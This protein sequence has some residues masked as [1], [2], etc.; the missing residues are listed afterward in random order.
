MPG[1]DEDVEFVDGQ[2]EPANGGD[3]IDCGSA[4]PEWTAVTVVVAVLVLAGA[5]LVLTSRHRDRPRAV[6]PPIPASAVAPSALAAPRSTFTAAALVEGALGCDTTGPVVGGTVS[7]TI[8]NRLD[9][10]VTI[11]SVV[12]PAQPGVTVAATG[13]GPS[14][15]RGST[16]P[17]LGDLHRPAGYRM[18]SGTVWV[19][20]QLTREPRCGVEVFVSFVITYSDR[21][22]VRR[23]ELGALGSEYACLTR[24]HQPRGHGAHQGS[25]TAG[26]DLKP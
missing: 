24:A 19:A 9:H 18:A 25:R 4:R 26:P 16:C 17:S 3:A 5:V 15:R 2:P 21:G 11:L 12:V 7:G 14:R 22:R 6:R 23:V 20:A 13:I 1:R 10:P 8:R